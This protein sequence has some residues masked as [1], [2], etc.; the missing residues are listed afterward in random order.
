M[1]L[2]LVTFILMCTGIVMIYS[3]SS[4]YALERYKDSFFFLKRHLIFLALGAGAMF[5]AMSLDYKKI[6]DVSKPLLLVAIVLLLLV[7][8]PGIGREVSGARR[9]FRF[10]FISFQPSEFANLAI[11]VYAADF[12]SRRENAIRTSVRALLPV[13]T[14]L[15]ICSLL[16]LMQPDLGTT[17]A[18]GFVVFTMLFLSG[19]RY[20]YFLYTIAGIV[21][22]LY[23]LVF[24]VPYRRNRIMAFLNPWADP[25]GTG[26]QIIQSQVAFGSGGFFGVGLGR[27]MQKLFYLPAAHTD[28]IFS[29][30]GEELGFVGTACVIALFFIFIALCLKI[31]KSSTDKFGYLLCLGLTLMISFKAMVNIGVSCGML[32]TK[33]LPLPFISYGG[34]SLIFD[35]VA[36]GLI[37]N[38]SRSAEV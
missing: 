4:I 34:S 20:T 13:V 10:K 22:L 1:Q 17:V 21:P 8:I 9:W 24:S 30:I 7:L 16:I 36:L 23:L 25:R 38:V 37:L 28:F 31:I 29:I 33:G 6:K 27:S 5:F 12:I 19:V 2:L 14:V 3:A 35:M 18:I 26:F 11:I 15:G 32:P